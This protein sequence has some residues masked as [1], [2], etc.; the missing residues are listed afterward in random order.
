MRMTTIRRITAPALAS[1]LTLT[2]AM[3]TAQAADWH[4]TTSKASQ[5]TANLTWDVVVD[6]EYTICWRLDSASGTVCDGE[7]DTVTPRTSSNGYFTDSQ[8][9]HMTVLL[10]SLV[11]G[12]DYKLRIKRGLLFDTKVFRINC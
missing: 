6:K 8:G 3:G 9:A 1:L 2:A 7:S 5:T 11:C 4:I 12:Q 10:Y